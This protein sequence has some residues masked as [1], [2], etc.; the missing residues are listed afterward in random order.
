MRRTIAL[1]AAVSVIVLTA[2]CAQSPSSSRETGGPAQSQRSSSETGGPVN[3]SQSWWGGTT[4]APLQ[5]AVIDLYVKANPTVSIDQQT[6]EFSAYW[7][8]LAVQAS[9]KNLPDVTQMQD[10]YVVR[11][12]SSLLDLTPYINDGTVD[13]S[14]VDPAVLAAGQVDGKQVMIPSSF[15]YRALEYDADVFS[16]AGV[17]PPDATTTWS[18]LAK[19]LKAV[20][21]S[22]KLAAGT[23]AATNQCL[24]DVV[25]YSYLKSY[26]T[27][28]FNKG[29]VA[30]D[31]NA[32]SGYFQ[33]WKDLQ[34]AG[35]V[36]PADFQA[37]NEGANI[38]D[39]MFTK[40]MT[41]LQMVPGNQF[42]ASKARQGNIKLAGLPVGPDGPGNKLVVSGQSI[43]ANS[44]NP[45]A[46][47]EFIN[48]FINDEAAA[49]AYKADN[50]IPSSTASRKAVAPLNIYAVSFYDTIKDNFAAFEPLPAV[51]SRVNDLLKRVCDQVAFDQASPDDA[52]ATLLAELK[53][54]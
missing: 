40:G 36:P 15:S 52:A 45:K 12:A 47:A 5:Q 10:R 30:F 9:G 42:E 28:V 33:Y 53:A 34:Q 31:V 43:G 6:A 3:L 38:E 46:A 35:V 50:G 26:G 19:N 48:F 41:A 32:A 4:R 17:N 11:F 22:G 24:V 23:Y 7:D 51:S 16:A 20:T 54:P 25:F 49:A 2:G 14:G 44:K 27:D 1:A 39:S 29:E 21:T 18:D 13:V 37:A 8:R